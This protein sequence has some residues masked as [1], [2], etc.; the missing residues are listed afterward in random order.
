MRRKTHSGR[1][2]KKQVTQPQ[3]DTA[4]A[5]ISAFWDACSRDGT[6]EAICKYAD[7]P[8]IGGML[9]I[10][11]SGEMDDSAFPYGIGAPYNGAELRDKGLEVIE[12]PAHTYAVFT[13][14]G[15]MPDA[16]QKTYQQICTSSFPKAATRTA[17]A[18]NWRCT[19]PPIPRTRTTLCRF[20][21]R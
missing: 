18:W 16:F 20:G 5:D 7:F 2:Q 19:L 8:Q 13:C 12:I 4:T 1:L 14:R 15:K 11:F 10:C 6:L 3:G 21:S 17:T 9:G